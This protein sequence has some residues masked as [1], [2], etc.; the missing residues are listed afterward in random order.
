MFPHPTDFFTKDFFIKSDIINVSIVIIGINKNKN[1]ECFSTGITNDWPCIMLDLSTAG[2][3]NTIVVGQ[4]F[5][6]TIL[7]LYSVD[8]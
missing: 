8:I 3:Q 6:I 7:K 5:V 4:E 1:L 2:P